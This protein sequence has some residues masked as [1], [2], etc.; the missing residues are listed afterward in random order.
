MASNLKDKQIYRAAVA[1]IPRIVEVISEL[2]TKHQT[3]AL[4]AAERGYRQTMLEAGVAEPIAT[5]MVTALMRR[6]QRHVA[7][8]GSVR[9]KVLKALHQELLGAKPGSNETSTRPAKRKRRRSTKTTMV[10]EP[11]PPQDGLDAD[12]EQNEAPLPSSTKVS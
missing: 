4:A 3:E 9:D 1:G 10:P 8:R 2:P 12:S 5:K 7:K 6:L 11:M